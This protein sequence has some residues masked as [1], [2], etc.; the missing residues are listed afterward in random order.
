MARSSGRTVY[1]KTPSGLVWTWLA[2]AHSGP[3]TTTPRMCTGL[4]SRPARCGRASTP[5]RPGVRSSESRSGNST[6]RRIVMAEA[7]YETAYRW[8]PTWL[9]ELT[10]K[11]A[12]RIA[13]QIGRLPSVELLGT[14][15]AAIFDRL[16]IDCVLDVGAHVGQYGRF[17]RNI[18]YTGHIVSFEPVRAN[19][20]RL[21]RRSERDAKW[22]IHRLALGN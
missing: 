17:L 19:F 15:L 7:V 9:K 16:K 10:R 5:A 11:G 18:G 3:P 13:C 4:I 8:T 12:T 14:H 2:T 22:T 6:R 1:P 20:A 21:E